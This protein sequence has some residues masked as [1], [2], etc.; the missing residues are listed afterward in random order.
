MNIKLDK[1]AV[2]D[3]LRLGAAERMSDLMYHWTISDLVMY[4]D[5]DDQVVAELRLEEIK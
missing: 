4:E 3:L 5:E 1:E 2:K